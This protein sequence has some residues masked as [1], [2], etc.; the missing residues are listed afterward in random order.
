MRYGFLSVQLLVRQGVGNFIF[1]PTYKMPLDIALRVPHH[2]EDV[3]LSLTEVAMARP[4]FFPNLLNYILG[5]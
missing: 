5:V 1:L 3:S 2:P 4:T